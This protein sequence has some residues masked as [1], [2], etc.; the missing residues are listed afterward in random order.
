MRYIEEQIVDIR[1][2]KIKNGL[3]GDEIILLLSQLEFDIERQCKENNNF[4][5]SNNGITILR[6]INKDI[7]LESNLG[8]DYSLQLV[9]KK[10]II[11]YDS[12]PALFK[13]ICLPGEKKE[14]VIK[15][16]HGM[17]YHIHYVVIIRKEECRTNVIFT[18]NQ[19]PLSN[20]S[21]PKLYCEKH[22]DGIKKR[23]EAFDRRRRN[24][25]YDTSSS[26]L[27]NI[28]IS[29]FKRPGAESFILWPLKQLKN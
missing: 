8:L 23:P 1:R 26:F 4:N 20:T 6:N 28:D 9:G 15:E 12:H 14:G 24:S 7:F 21:I 22:G 5:I 11:N 27:K 13:L 19:K 10:P 25:I 29:Y 16:N 17:G 18:F 2:I 3:V